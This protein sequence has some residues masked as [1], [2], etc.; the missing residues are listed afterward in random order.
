[1]FRSWVSKMGD[2][3]SQYMGVCP[4][5]RVPLLSPP[6]GLSGEDMLLTDKDSLGIEGPQYG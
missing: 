1:M 6:I 4:V 3:Y 2:Y 5:N